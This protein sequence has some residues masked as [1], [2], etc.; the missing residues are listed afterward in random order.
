M[1]G[2][3][4]STAGFVDR[5][6]CPI[7]GPAVGFL[8]KVAAD[9]RAALWSPVVL[10]RREGDKLLVMSEEEASDDERPEGEPLS[11]W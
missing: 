2:L 5:W 10:T 7:G 3:E 4:P 8:P 11:P 6:H 9:W 1:E